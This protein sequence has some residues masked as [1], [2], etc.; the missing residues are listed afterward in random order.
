MAFAL[1]YESTHLS[2][3]GKLKGELSLSYDIS[4]DYILRIPRGNQVPS[5]PH[6]GF[7][8][9]FHGQ[10]E[11][12]LCFQVPKIFRGVCTYFGISLHQL[13]PNA[14]RIL[15]GVVVI[16]QLYDIPLTLTFFHYFFH[17]KRVELGAFHFMSRAGYKFLDSRPLSHKGWKNKFF[18]LEPLTPFTFPTDYRGELPNLTIL[19]KYKKNPKYLRALEILI[20]MCFN[21]TTII[22][23]EDFLYRARLSPNTVDLEKSLGKSFLPFIF[24]E[25]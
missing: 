17:P 19:G 3:T 10:V 21:C 2:L 23:N 12:G 22:H 15:C 14:I 25:N 11:S 6:P 1:W 9:F 16:F 7:T 5:M 18:Y 20:S 4:I 24:H 13:A 8:T